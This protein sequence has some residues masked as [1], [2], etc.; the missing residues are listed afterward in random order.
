MRVRDRKK[1]IEEVLLNRKVWKKKR[2]ERMYRKER[3]KT[4]S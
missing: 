1:V 4:F 3:R 2:L